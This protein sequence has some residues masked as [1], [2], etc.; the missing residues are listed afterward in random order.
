DSLVTVALVD[1]ENVTI[2]YTDTRAATV[3]LVKNTIGGDDSFDFDG[4]GLLPPDVDLNTVGGTANQV[5]TFTDLPAAGQAA[6]ITELLGNLPPGWPFTN[7]QVTGDD[8]SVISNQ[9]ATLN[10]E[11]GED[12]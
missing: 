1:G 5:F 4:T 12:I 9:T 8:D 2:T 11:P 10:V 3:T 7:L 6:S